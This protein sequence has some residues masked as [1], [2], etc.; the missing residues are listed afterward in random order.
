MPVEIQTFILATTPLLELRGAIPV[1]L[2]VHEMS[3]IS[4]YVWSVLGNLVPMFAIV[5]LFDPVSFWLSK[6]SIL[7]ERFFNFIF[8]KTRRDHGDKVE[9]CGYFALAMFTSIPLPVSGAWTGSLIAVVFGLK[10]RYSL[11]AITAGVLLAGIGVLLIVEAGV[12]IE[13]RYGLQAVLGLALFLALVYV[14]IRKRVK[15]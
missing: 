9:K 10:K 4:A 14:I 2:L 12:G 5:F 3:I 7:M 6:K 11:M 8:Q 1:A 13:E 15:R